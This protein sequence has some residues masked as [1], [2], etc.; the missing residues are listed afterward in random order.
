MLA[1]EEE[2]AKLDEQTTKI[3]IYYLHRCGLSI[4]LVAF[5]D[6][7]GRFLAFSDTTAHYSEKLAAA[8]N[9]LTVFYYH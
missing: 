2:I 3:L 8:L 9:E 7:F 1:S 5:Q 4:L 6:I